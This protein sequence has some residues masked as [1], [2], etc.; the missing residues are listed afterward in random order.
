M[1]RLKLALSKFI[2]QNQIGGKDGYQQGIRF[3]KWKELAKIKG[4]K[5][6]VYGPPSSP[7]QLSE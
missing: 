7:T 5:P 3:N 6:R 4:P 2:H 1:N